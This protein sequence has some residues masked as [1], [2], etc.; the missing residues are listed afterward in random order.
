MTG[1]LLDPATRALAFDDAFARTGVRMTRSIRGRGAALALVVTLGALARPA[2]AQAPAAAPRA[3]G[4]RA[5]AADVRFMQ[6]MIGHHAQALEMAALVP[7]RSR[8][9]DLRA[10]AERIDVSQRDELAMMRRWLDARGQSVPATDAH[11]GHDVAHAATS[12][13]SAAM[14]G[15]LSGD[16]MGRLARATGADFDRRFLEGMIRHHEGALTM[17]AEFFAAP[18]AAQEAEIFRL[19]SDVDADQRAEI[20]RMRA[21]LATMAATR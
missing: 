20:R 16:A 2:G 7:T 21:L 4:V 13:S 11:A 5:A 17:V 1:K 19:A 10:L 18:G 6:R 8:R 15:M 14:P 12:D 3:A 9:A